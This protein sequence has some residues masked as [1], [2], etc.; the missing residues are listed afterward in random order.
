MHLCAKFL[1]GY[2]MH[3]GNKGGCPPAPSWIRCWRKPKTS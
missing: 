1:L 3:P 2:K